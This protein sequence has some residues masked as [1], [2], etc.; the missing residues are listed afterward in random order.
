M[1]EPLSHLFGANVN[2]AAAEVWYDVEGAQQA[3][4]D[5]IKNLLML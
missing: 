5:E 1:T 3:T 4:V 2:R